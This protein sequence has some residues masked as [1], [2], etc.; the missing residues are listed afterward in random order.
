MSAAV[1]AQFDHAGVVHDSPADCRQAWTGG[2][3]LTD[4]DVGRLMLQGAKVHDCA[5]W[6]RTFAYSDGTTSPEAHY[7]SEHRPY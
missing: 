4:G 3:F 2:A 7:V 1:T 5:E 6:R